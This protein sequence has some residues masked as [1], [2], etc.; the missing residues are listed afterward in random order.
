M[1]SVNILLGVGSA[2][3][4]KIANEVSEGEIVRVKFSRCT[5]KCLTWR[6]SFR[7]KDATS[8]IDDS[9]KISLLIGS[10]RKTY[11]LDDRLMILT[12][13]MI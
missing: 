1:Q 10:R 6:H 9:I 11:F 2:A 4:E 7:Y 8:Y 3:K 13:I 5:P 12:P